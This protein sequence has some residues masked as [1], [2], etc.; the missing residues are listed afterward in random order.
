MR[1]LKRFAQGELRL[2]RLEAFSDTVFGIIVTL[3][4]LELKVP[5]L[6]IIAAWANWAITCLSW[7]R[8]S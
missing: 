8:S 5:S 7:F 4:V 2:T 3:L 6:T 1:F